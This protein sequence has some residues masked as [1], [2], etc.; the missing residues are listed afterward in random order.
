[1]I[2][3]LDILYKWGMGGGAP[4][5][6]AAGK[7]FTEGGDGGGSRGT[8][9]SRAQPDQSALFFKRLPEGVIK[10]CP[11]FR[12]SSRD[13]LPQTKI[14]CFGGGRKIR[15]IIG[16]APLLQTFCLDPPIWVGWSLAGPLSP[17]P[18]KHA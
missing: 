18:P 7:E 16:P 9:S 14:A 8:G 10:K 17:P 11:V 13:V 2:F 5:P 3:A 6:G 12:N 4:G 1:M 15:G